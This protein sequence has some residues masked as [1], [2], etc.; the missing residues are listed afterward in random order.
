MYPN[1]KQQFT[2]PI[3]VIV[4]VLMLMVYLVPTSVSFADIAYGFQGKLNQIK[5]LNEDDITVIEETDEHYLNQINTPYDA[6]EDVT[7]VFTMSA[8]IN[9]FGD[10][11]NFRANAFPHIKIYDENMQ[12]VVSEYD[13][14]N[15]TLK[16]IGFADRYITIGV[17]KGVLKPGN[18]VI[19]F[20]KDVCGN[21]IAKTLQVPVIFKFTVAEKS[22]AKEYNVTFD[23]NNGQEATVKTVKEN[24]ALD[25]KPEAPAKAGYTFVG[26]YKDVDDITTAYE[27]GKTYTEDVTY[28]AKYAH[29]E[30]LGAQVK[31]VVDGKSGIRF[32]TKVYNDGDQIV[33]KGTLI[34]PVSVLGDQELTLDTPS[35]A[36]SVGTTNYE[37]N[38]EQNYIIYLGTIVNVKEAYFDRAMTA[39]SYVTYKDKAGNQ[40]TV[41]SPYKNGSTTIN[42]LLNS[43]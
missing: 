24:E 1:K 8:G 34:I 42:A 29:V 22:A 13:G 5:M 4:T 19:Y 6:A 36:K 7:F 37:V 11:S 27:A 20:G 14:G 38:T 43:K 23:P 35:V 3:A 15:G 21:N 10:G 28:T 16:Y 18:Y 41:Y 12:N 2:K 9:A 31:A 33:E 17:D 40:Y 30:M 32:G 39:S 25:Y 26:W